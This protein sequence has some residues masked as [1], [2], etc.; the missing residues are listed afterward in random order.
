LIVRLVITDLFSDSFRF[1]FTAYWNNW[2]HY[3]HYRVYCWKGA[4]LSGSPHKTPWPQVFLP[5]YSEENGSSATVRALLIARVT[6]LW[7]LAQL[8]DIRLGTILPRSVI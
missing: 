2:Y 6:C 3:W 1:S 8:P 7:C 4:T 5:S